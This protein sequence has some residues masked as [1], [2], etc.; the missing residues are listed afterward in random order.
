MCVVSMIGDYYKD[1]FQQP[2]YY[3][4]LQPYVQPYLTQPSTTI[5]QF[6]LPN[7]TRE[8]FDSLKKEVLEM[9]ELLKRAK[10]YDE[11]NGEPECEVED[12]VELLRKVAK[13]VGISLDDVLKPKEA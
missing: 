5:Q 11:K 7:I 13:L 1:R 3:P 2:S 10:I 4:G 8:E 12:K 9:K 6:Q